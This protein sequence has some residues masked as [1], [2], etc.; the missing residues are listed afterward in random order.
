MPRTATPRQAASA[1]H[2]TS[3][4]EHGKVSE[5]RRL[6]S[7]A[8]RYDVGGYEHDLGQ[9]EIASRP[10]GG[11]P[12]PVRIT[13]RDPRDEG[14]AFRAAV[15][16]Q[17]PGAG[18]TY[19]SKIPLTKDELKYWADRRDR[20]RVV[21]K[22]EFMLSL[23]DLRTEEGRSRAQKI[24]P[25]IIE[26]QE[27]AIQTKAELQKRIAMIR[28]RGVQDKEDAELLYMLHSG[29]IAQDTSPLFDPSGW[30]GKAQS[31]DAELTRGM[32]NPTNRSITGR[33]ATA[34]YGPDGRSGGAPLFAVSG[35]DFTNTN[36]A[37][38]ALR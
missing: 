31:A 8:A 15:A 25:E 10:S 12:Y 37:G 34:Q 17:T 11:L 16:S 3:P 38:A 18:L 13:P 30:A 29:Q 27:Q 7:E 33:R 28:L 4:D 20:E 24:I 2:T 26:Q 5:V 36:F 21:A 22:A 9:H 32:F 1:G 14:M 6:D 35:A 23:C 19:D